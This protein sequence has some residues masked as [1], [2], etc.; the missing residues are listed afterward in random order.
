MATDFLLP[1]LGENIE[2]ADVARILVKEGDV[3]AAEQAIVE[4][5]TDKA[6]L[7]LPSPSAGTVVK[8]YVKEGGSI[9]VG[10]PV[11]SIESAAAPASATQPAP[12]PQPPPAKSQTS[13]APIPAAAPPLAPAPGDSGRKAVVAAL[14]GHV[15]SKAS[16]PIPA[17]PSTR[18]L[19][20]ELGVDLVRV[21]GSGPGG[22]ITAEDV[23]QFV[24]GIL[25]GSPS[26]VGGM[27]G[28]PR[29]QPL[30]DFTAY[31]PTERKPLNKI[32]KVAA[33]NLS[34]AWQSI[35]HVT[36]HELVDITELEARRKNSIKSRGEGA[37][38][39]TMT[40]LAMKAAVACLK[41]F[42][43]FNA[44]FDSAADEIVLK[45]YY[46]IGIA[47]DTEHGLVVPVVKNVDQ[48]TILELSVELSEIAAKARARKLDVADFRGGTF[49]ISNLGGIGG[50][51]FTPIVNWPEVAILG[52]SRS[53]TKLSLVDGKVESRLLMPL[54]LSYDHRVVNGADA[55]RFCVKLA[56]VLTDPFELLVET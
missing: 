31:G 38:K 19:A 5:E 56:A 20:R 40:V 30:P 13:Q 33:A 10:A 18:R 51:S 6:V 46:N 15:E 32:A 9:A 26:A 21:D 44:S 28:I 50:T 39:I 8:I 4:L 1:T 55:A 17:G 49:T 27:A 54:S 41:A 43:Q 37:P 52:I 7:E 25:A 35:P 36:Q 23:Q 16:G 42:P 3:V 47:V 11:M 29:T 34:Y 2:K 12:P 45:Q 24:R 48:K 53:R 22:R 14:N